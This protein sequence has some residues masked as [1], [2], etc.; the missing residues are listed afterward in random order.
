MNIESREAV[1]DRL[2]WYLARHAEPQLPTSIRTPTHWRNDESSFHLWNSNCHLMVM[3]GSRVTSRIND[4]VDGL[5]F[6]S[7]GC[8]CGVLGLTDARWEGGLIKLVAG[9]LEPTS[10]PRAITL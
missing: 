2:R 3:D 9:I 7:P 6:R 10:D 1:T 4:G 5:E 8:T